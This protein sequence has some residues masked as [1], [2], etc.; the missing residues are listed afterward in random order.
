VFTTLARHL[1]PG[2]VLVFNNHKNSDSLRRR[3]LRLVG[4]KAVTRGTMSHP[5]VEALVAETDLR[6][7]EV[8]PLAILPLSERRALLPLALAERLERKMS[9][10]GGLA[11]IAQDLI[12]VCGRGGG[13]STSTG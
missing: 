11:G 3:L 9:G 13:R 6:I 2:G 10:R 4:R 5:E 8:V 1:A 7:L 12:Y